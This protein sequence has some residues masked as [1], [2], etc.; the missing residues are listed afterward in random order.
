M[1]LSK[2]RTLLIGLILALGMTL[3]VSSVI[4]ASDDITVTLNGEA[5]SFDQAPV[6]VNGRT[7]VPIR[8]V[9]EA[10]GADVYWDGTHQVTWIVKNDLKL[11]LHIGTTTLYTANVDSFMDFFENGDDSAT[12]IPLDVPPQIIGNRTLLP[13]RAV[14]EALGATVDWDADSRTV[15]ITCADE[16]INDK[17]TDIYFFDNYMKYQEDVIFANTTQMRKDEENWRTS[18]SAPKIYLNSTSG[19]PIAF[20]ETQPTIDAA[21]NVFVPASSIPN[22]FLGGINYTVDGGTVTIQQDGFIEPTTVSVTLGS[23]TLY[24][25]NAATEMPVAPMMHR[26]QLYIPLQPIGAALGHYI[27]YDERFDEF[28]IYYDA[29]TIYIWN[30]NEDSSENGLRYAIFQGSDT[31]RSLSEL[32]SHAVSDFAEIKALFNHIPPGDINLYLLYQIKGYK[33]PYDVADEIEHAIIDRFGYVCGVGQRL[34]S[35]APTF[36]QGTGDYSDEWYSHQLLALG[37]G[38]IRNN[39]TQTYRFSCFRSFHAPFSIRVDINT[40]GTGILTFSMCD[41]PISAYGGELIQHTTQ[42]LSKAQVDSLLKSV[43]QNKFW[44]MPT[45]ID[46][47]GL[48][49]SMWILEGV[50]N[51]NYHIVERWTPRDGEIYELGNLFMKLSGEDLKDIY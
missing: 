2:T 27:D 36:I 23:K 9:C 47:L 28:A 31:G 40:D 50:S 25:N 5:V 13:L 7:L 10:L 32:C 24:K 20:G 46:D 30:E 42:N 38:D 6:I 17:N 1:K 35:N 19:Y 44:D 26:G 51:G 48:D 37:E 21:G 3:S 4:W 14:C 12:E 41:R 16:L 39:E 22:V 49:G 8:A 34:I 45:S 11:L 15:V 29:A 33:I 18:S 43:N